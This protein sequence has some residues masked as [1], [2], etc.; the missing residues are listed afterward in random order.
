[1]PD[2]EAERTEKQSTGQLITQLSEET[3]RLIRDEMR[4]A[5]S[6]LKDKAKHAGIGA[7]LFGG[8]GVIALYG[9]GALVAAAVLALAL[10]V[11]PWL[12]ALIVAVV[13]FVVAGIAA[14]VGKKQVSQ[15][16]PPMPEQTTENVKK[17]IRA[18]KEHPTS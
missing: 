1:M 12:A 10:A 17:D 3:S 6:E 5:Q 7:G 9:V 8:A 13:L 15:G 2:R 14:L 18:V 11:T 16:V 4:L